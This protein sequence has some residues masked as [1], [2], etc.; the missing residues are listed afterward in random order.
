MAAGER[1][2]GHPRTRAERRARHKRI[3]GDE[4]LPPRGTGL[5]GAAGEDADQ[6]GVG[7][8]LNRRRRWR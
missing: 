5:K 6:R 8:R 7:R 1:R 2:N 3:Y 4:K